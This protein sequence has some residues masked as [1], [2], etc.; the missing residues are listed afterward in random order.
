MT[1]SHRYT[2]VLVTQSD[3][4][5]WSD[6]GSD[7]GVQVVVHGNSLVDLIL[8]QIRYLGP[9][10]FYVKTEFAPIFHK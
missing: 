4:Y 6:F 1:S 7:Y 10:G 5:H 8:L 2:L 9:V 3:D